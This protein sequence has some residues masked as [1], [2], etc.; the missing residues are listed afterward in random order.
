MKSIV[1]DVHAHFAPKL[2]AERFETN[3]D[4]F[5]MLRS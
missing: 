4:K 5:P 1:V 3:K 2:I